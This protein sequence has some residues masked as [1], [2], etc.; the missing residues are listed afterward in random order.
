VISGVKRLHAGAYL[1]DDTS[2]FVAQDHRGG[3]PGPRA[4]GGVETAMTDS[5][6]NHTHEHLSGMGV[7]ELHFFDPQ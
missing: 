3:Y 7:V 4:V 6:S 1:L 2:P 5:T